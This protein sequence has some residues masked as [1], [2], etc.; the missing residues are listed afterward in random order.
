MAPGVKPEVSQENPFHPWNSVRSYAGY[1][2]FAV[3]TMMATTAGSLNIA[4]G[5]PD[6]DTLAITKDN[7][8][9]VA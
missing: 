9:K 1:N 7:L 8:L 4:Q 3:A 5:Y 6:F 2:P